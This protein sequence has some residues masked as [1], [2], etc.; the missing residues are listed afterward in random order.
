MTPYHHEDLTQ[1][2]NVRARMLFQGCEYV[3]KMHLWQLCKEGSKVL[4]WNN[5][6]FPCKHPPFRWISYRRWWISTL[7]SMQNTRKTTFFLPVRFV[8]WSGSLLSKEMSCGS[9]LAT[10]RSPSASRFV[11]G[12]FP[13]ARVGSTPCMGDGHPTFNRE[14]L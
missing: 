14:S 11:M 10:R 8:S 7:N 13:C 2:Q 12:I 4:R 6:D 1:S 9:F 5:C 3:K